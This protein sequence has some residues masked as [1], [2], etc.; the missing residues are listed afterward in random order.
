MN[1][2]AVFVLA[3]AIAAGV[4]ILRRQT[5][6]ALPEPERGSWSAIPAQTR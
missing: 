2:R 4:A 5:T 6:P 1:L 3:A